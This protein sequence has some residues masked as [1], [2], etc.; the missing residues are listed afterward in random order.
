MWKATSL[1]STPLEEYALIGDCQSAALVARDGS[2]D[3]LCLPRF[4]SEACFAALLGGR[5]HG[6]WRVAPAGG[7]HRT[8]RRYRR[9][10]LI[11]ETRH[12]TDE[13]AVLVVDFMP[14][15]GE[16]PDLVR[17][18]IGER[19]RVPMRMDLVIRFGYGSIVPWVEQIDGGLQAI[20]GPDLLQLLTPVRTRGEDLSTV[21]EFVVA[22]GDRVPFILTWFPSH[23]ARRSTIEPERALAETDAF[24]TDW[25]A[26]RVDE[27]PYAE[28]VGRSLITLKALTYGPTGGIVAAPTTSL[29]EALGGPR[30]WDYRFCW[31]RDATFTLYALMNAGYNEEAA[32]WR[33]WLLRAIAGT[34][35]QLQIMY[36]IA[37]ERRLSEYEVGWLPG[38]ESSRPVRIGNAA[39]EQL[40]LDVW[41]ELMDALHLARRTRLGQDAEGWSLQRTL[42]EYLETIWQEPDQGIWEV[43]GPRRHFT[44]SKVMAWVA[45]DR[46]VRS[47]E[48]YGLGGP[49]DRWRA[50]RDDIHASVCREGFDSARGSFVQYYGAKDLDASLLMIPMVGFLPPDDERVRGTVRAIEQELLV[51]G[52]VTRYS[53]RRDVDGLAGGEGAFLPCSFWLADNYVLQ[54]RQQ[55]AR[56]LFERLLGLCN[57]VG[58]LSE[59]YDPVARRLVG[60]FPQAFSHVSLANTARN[61]TAERGPAEHRPGTPLANGGLR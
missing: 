15:R 13:G 18:V 6:R 45:L 5:E 20:A 52:F 23:R 42:V 25:S 9:G 55:E 1:V 30:N 48:E 2:I 7:V 33:K 14:L 47:I 53:P 36:G 21:A 34:P 43:R 16:E 12:E 31:I 37:G 8:T 10:T 56:D 49:V 40:Q 39:S 38:Y 19:G 58:L 51:G 26:S 54:G 27:G 61:V 22:A 57:D 24:W 32:A 4:D 3:W 17:I 50:V 60:N 41:G 46:A 35:A 44:H 28:Q 59:E 29:P 11:L